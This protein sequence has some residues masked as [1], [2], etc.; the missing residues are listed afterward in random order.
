VT[1]ESGFRTVAECAAFLGVS[2]KTIRRRLA[3]GSLRKA[4]LG[5]RAIRI[6]VSELHRL[7]GI[8]PTDDRTGNDAATSHE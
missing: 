8:E 3:D 2:E 7:C 6:P 4:P 1:C 5:G